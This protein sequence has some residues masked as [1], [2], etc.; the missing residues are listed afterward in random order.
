MNISGVGFGDLL[1]RFRGLRPAEQTAIAGA[2]LFL[3]H[4]PYSYFLLRLGPAEAVVMAAYSAL[5][6]M[7]VYYL[8]SALIRRRIALDASRQ[9]GPKKGLRLKK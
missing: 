7:L 5:L 3:I 1:L 2:L 8:T 9:R 6:F 4:I